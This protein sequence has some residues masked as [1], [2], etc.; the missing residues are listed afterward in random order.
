MQSL[1][2]NAEL[3]LAAYIQLVLGDTKDQLSDLVG[4]D[5][6][7]AK[8][9][10]EFARRYPSV[11]T[12]YNDA[13]SSFSAT[14]FKD[15][16]GDLALAIRGT[17]EVGDFIPTDAD[18][19]TYGAGYDQ[20]VAMYNW[21]RR[22][23]SPAGQGVNQYEV[24][25]VPIFDEPPVGALS[26][27]LGTSDA[28]IGTYYLVPAVPA[29]ATGELVDEIASDGGRRLAVTGHSLGGHLAMA[30]GALFP[31]VAGEVTVF[32]APGFLATPANEAFFAKLGGMLP[33]G[34]NTTNVIADEAGVGDEPW[35]AIAGLH[36]R[37]GVS[38]DIPVENQWF[39]GE[40]D[41]PSA[42][43][44]SQ[45]TLTDALAVY[46][47]LVGLAPT[48]AT[49]GF[50]SIL[51]SAALG[52]MSSLERVV[53]ALERLFVVDEAL[54]PAGN[55][56]RDALYQA[57]YSIQGSATYQAALVSA[58]FAQIVPL[59][60]LSSEQM[61]ALAATDIAYRYALVN[62]TPFAIVTADPALYAPHNLNGELAAETFTAE[63]LSD[64][65]YMLNRLLLRNRI[66]GTLTGPVREEFR[67]V[68][69]GLLFHVDATNAAPARQYVFGGM[70]ADALTGLAADDRL[71]GGGGDDVISGGDGNDYLEGGKGN[72]TLEGGAGIDRLAGG[73]DNDIYVYNSGDGRDTIIDS[74]GQGSVV[75]DGVT[76]AGGSRIAEGVWCSVDEAFSYAFDGDL[77]SGGVLVVNDELRIENFTNGVLGIVL[78]D[79]V[80]SAP[81]E[82]ILQGTIDHD[83]LWFGQESTTA[84]LDNQYVDFQA[85]GDESNDIISTAR[86]NDYVDAGAGSDWIVTSDGDDEVRAGDGNDAIFVGAGRNRVDGGPGDDLIVAAHERVFDTSGTVGMDEAAWVDVGWGFGIQ[87]LPDLFLD[88]AG[89]VSWF[90]AL[91]VPQSAVSGPSSHDPHT[92]FSYEPVSLYEGSILYADGPAYELGYSASNT[93]DTA[94][95][96]LAGGDGNDALAGNAGDDMLLGGSGDDRLAGGAGNDLL[97][98]GGGEDLLFGSVG[99][100]EMDGGGEDD[101]AYGGSGNDRIHGGLG[102]DTLAGDNGDIDIGGADEI[103]GAGGDDRLSGNGGDDRVFGGD[104]NDALWGHEGGDTLWGENGAD[105]LAGG[106]GDDILIG[107]SDADVLL[108]ERGD[109]RLEGGLGDDLLDG[110]EGADVL[111]GGAGTDMLY[112]DDADVV[113]VRG[114]GGDD[115]IIWS[116]R[117][118]KIVLEGIS[119][120]DLSV[121]QLDEPDGTQ[122]FGLRFGA[123]TVRIPNGFLNNGLMFSVQDSDLDL[124]AVMERATAVNLTGTQGAD[125]LYGSPQGD[126]LRGYSPLSAN[127]LDDL[128][129]GQGG[130]DHIEG[131]S[132]NDRLDGGSGADALFGGPGDDV[133]VIDDIGDI[134]VEGIDEGADTVEASIDFAAPDA[135]ENVA[136]LGSSAIHATGNAAGNRLFGNIAANRLAGLDG[137]DMLLGRAGDDALEGGAGADQLYGEDGNDRLDGGSQNDALYGGAGDDVFVAVLGS[138]ADVVVDIEGAN[139]IEFGA[140]IT[141]ESLDVTQYQGD[142]GAYYLRIAY[143]AGGDAI[144]VKNGLSGVIQ[145]YRF[146]DGTSLGHAELMNGA[147]APVLIEGTSHND[148]IDGSSMAD[149][150]QGGS[151]DDHL[152]GAAGNDVLLGGEGAD[153]LNGGADDDALD[154]GT[155]NDTLLGGAGEDRYVL[156]WGMGSD[157]AIEYGAEQNTLELGA[158][159]RLTD[160]EII[161]DQNDVVVRFAGS[162]QGLRIRGYAAAPQSWRIQDDAGVTRALDELITGPYSGESTHEFAVV[163]ARFMR[164]VRA[165]FINALTAPGASTG[166]AIGADG[167]LS[168]ST[169][170]VSSNYVGTSHYSARVHFESVD[171]ESTAFVQTTPAFDLQYS[172]TSSVT[173]KASHTATLGSYGG[174]SGGYGSGPRRYHSMDDGN[175][176]YGIPAGGGVVVV[177]GQSQDQ[178]G[179]QGPRDD[180]Y[181]G[182]IG[183]VR[184]IGMWVFESGSGTGITTAVTHSIDHRDATLTLESVMGES[185]NNEIAV[186]GNAIVDGGDGNDRIVATADRW[187]NNYGYDFVPDR[188]GYDVPFDSRDVGALLY[189]NKGTDSIAGGNANDLLMGGDGGD[190]LDGRLGEDTYVVR[191]GDAGY[192]VIADSGMFI[193]LQFEVPASRYSDWYYRSIGIPDYESRMDI[194]PLPV[195][196]PNDFQAMEE[197]AAAAVIE[198]DTV[199]FSAGIS[200]D[201]LTLTWGE[202]VLD[203]FV[204]LTDYRNPWMGGVGTAFATL[205]IS[206][207]AGEG[208]RVVIPHTF[209]PER[210]ESGDD[211]TVHPLFE[212]S[213]S[214]EYLGLGIERFRFSDGTTLSLAE[215]VA[216]APPPPSFDPHIQDPDMV[217]TGTE[218]DDE[219]SGG[220]GDDT[221]YGMAGNDT[222]RGGDGNDVLE[223]GSGSDYAF[224]G[225]GNDSIRGGDIVPGRWSPEYLYGEDGD[226]V[227]VGGSK[228]AHLYGGAGNDDLQAGSGYQNLYGEDGDDILTSGSGHAQLNGGAGAD[229]M[230]G[231]GF[232]NSYWIDNPGDVIVEGVGGGYDTVNSSIDYALAPDLEHLN[233]I[234]AAAISGAGNAR[235]NTLT[236]NMNAAANTLSG[237]PGDDTYIIGIGDAIVELAGEGAETVYADFSYAL[238]DNLENLMLTGYAAINAAGNSLDNRLVGNSASNMLNGGAGNDY[239]SGMYGND[240]MNGGGGA[241]DL[242][243]GYGNDSYIIDNPEA[244]VTEFSGQG[245]DTV[246]SSISYTLTANV[247]RLVLTGL[248][249]STGQGNALANVLIGNSAINSLI[250][251]GGGDTLRGMGGN[252]L[253]QGEAGNDTLHGGD[254]DD[255]MHGDAGIDTLIGGWGS[256]EYVFGRGGG[257]DLINDYDS[258]DADPVN[259]GA[260]TDAVRFGTGIAHNQLWFSRVGN[261]LL[262]R[263]V[264]TS[265]RVSVQNWYLGGDYQTEEFQTSDGYILLNTQVEQLVQAMSAFSPPPS[266]E[267]TLPDSYRQELDPVIAAN[268]QAAA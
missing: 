29:V 126:R 223:T 70:A 66:D 199:E 184:A 18:I 240:I 11:L 138:G 193:K 156:S 194:P 24:R 132:G 78:G 93:P 32:N 104:G 259:Y 207:A 106:G 23:A 141:R 84:Y 220:S 73:A 163:S 99:D 192:D 237:G 120:S 155:G 48:L 85:L 5:G 108:G 17:L 143:G 234:G 229:R 158:G 264:G 42:R 31:D 80:S 109:D 211:P 135:I 137:D 250:G 217:L 113:I 144:A 139:V 79:A 133:Y 221:L 96:R 225:A 252:D 186:I 60:G 251:G 206:W 190:F 7:S 115:H 256:D 239:L 76:L 92:S 35:S 118:G 125:M 152:S 246:N 134:A 174:I 228:H 244:T 145:G 20:I 82:K 95:N 89:E 205:D 150:I 90:Y 200:L 266:G 114:G 248:A 39:S 232:N 61:A 181:T 127:D 169:S 47:A 242:L 183:S 236:G 187:E 130:A 166:Y 131:G 13:V 58:D 107:G 263:V 245:M 160:L 81:P 136:L 235:N 249:D 91:T 227:I 25:F 36:G 195:F 209:V 2:N 67:D 176:G 233:L 212:Q 77:T 147:T 111:D 6:M 52:S 86:G 46:A 45:Q 201:Q 122:S 117:N 216:L 51:D 179:G 28:R 260:N 197:L 226:D 116:G 171:T 110:G 1:F 151:G 103:H 49:I 105:G 254:G 218:G 243:G 83:F 26:L 257:L 3:A 157:I 72:D 68:G 182:D 54:L 8:Q 37:P 50:K 210:F 59:T 38:V 258:R 27:Y 142:D 173:Y 153:T 203:S 215:M 41:P 191:R 154:G 161:R 253:L 268:W 162:E 202:H 188:Y 214:D 167:V 165:N 75:F 128:L 230:I 159:V 208:I 98:G 124:Q 119:S 94:Q 140:G 123:D 262:V 64:R 189:G 100:D 224:G 65:A 164:D 238:G 53:D 69:T 15:T 57:I 219:L 170:I 40:P 34:V 19:K 4:N 149:S 146:A 112:A 71:Y 267:W 148:M 74:D 14:V 44:H 87:V 21:W 88:D 204:A 213:R 231:N 168:K 121:S 178:D 261:N 222:L 16:S 62:L 12:Q 198:T 172:Y 10:E 180:S 43:N 185:A 55:A 196:S 9:A 255:A 63:Y 177:Y 97:M 56:N 247:E 101:I 22:I 102:N 241:D 175:T 33:V 265:D 30:F 129:Y